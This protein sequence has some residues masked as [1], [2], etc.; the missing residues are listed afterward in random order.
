MAAEQTIDSVV[1]NIINNYS[2]LLVR[3]VAHVSKQIEDGIKQKAINVL[4]EYYYG[5]YTPKSYD[6]IEAL[7]HSIVSFSNIE[8]VKK[9][10]QC[11]VGV[12]YSPEALEDYL[13]TLGGSAYKASKKYG[14]ATAS[15][16]VNNFL[17]GKHPYTDGS[18]EPGTE[19]KYKLSPVKQRVGMDITDSTGYGLSYYRD[20]M[21]PNEV[22]K[23][24][25]I[26]G[27]KLF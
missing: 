4:H 11:T 5:A 26:E 12:E 14:R 6:R 3:A 2:T 23:Y 16:V 7:Q 22:M 18:Q 13:N 15:W 24:M 10:V 17:E 27:T 25:L 20:I 1:N 19:V 9:G 8:V 21:F